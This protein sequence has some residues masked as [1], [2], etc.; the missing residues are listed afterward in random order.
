LGQTSKR[1]FSHETS[2]YRQAL[3]N[4]IEHLGESD[5][6]TISRMRATLF[7]SILESPKGDIVSAALI[8]G[9]KH[10]LASVR[11][12]YSTF[13]IQ[14][15]RELHR[16][17]AE[18]IIR[19]LEA[20][21]WKRPDAIQMKEV[22]GSVGSRG[23]VLLNTIKRKIGFLQ[24][25]VEQDCALKGAQDR[26]KEFRIKHNAF[27]LLAVWI[28]D[29]SVGMRAI[30]SPYFHSSEYD[31]ATRMGTFT[32]KDPG[33]GRKSRLFRLPERTDA[34]MQSHDAYL[35][36]LAKLPKL[37]LPPSTR[38]LPCYF[39]RLDGAKF[40]PVAVSPSSIREMFG[41]FFPFAANFARRLVRTEAIERG[42]PSIYVDAY[43]G[44]AYRGEECTNPFSSFDPVHYLDAM[45][46]AVNSVLDQLDITPVSLEPPDL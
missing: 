43:C 36:N 9:N 30:I 33:G 22:Q 12:S 17:G 27:T 24:Q 45:E 6:I 44:H 1:I 10:R 15:L 31:S 2:W 20:A 21:G 7:E 29:I 34:F 38:N 16:I 26:R 28:V 41:S 11:I 39:L 25:L 46:A 13:S 4:F 8:T 19:T 35:A 42:V 18:R 5:R 40:V 23:C 14:H 37:G 32:D 3:K